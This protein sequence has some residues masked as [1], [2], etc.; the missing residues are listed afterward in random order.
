MITIR[1]QHLNMITTIMITITTQKHN[2]KKF[3]VKKL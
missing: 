1:S 2:K 3:E